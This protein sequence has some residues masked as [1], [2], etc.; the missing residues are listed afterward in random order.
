LA[1]FIEI[2][3]EKE[4]EIPEKLIFLNLVS[5]YYL[6]RTVMTDNSH[7]PNGLHELNFFLFSLRVLNIFS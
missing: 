5:R 3:K 4:E 7:N 1:G 6:F 2:G